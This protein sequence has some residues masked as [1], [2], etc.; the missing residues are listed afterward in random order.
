MTNCA[1]SYER[2][3][4]SGRGK[5]VCRR[6]LKNCLED[7]VAVVLLASLAVLLGLLVLLMLY[8]AANV[9]PIL[10][11]VYL[12]VLIP[13]ILYTVRT[14]VSVRNTDKEHY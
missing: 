11:P 14:I 3:R 13:T 2:C 5:D 8:V 7:K 10:Y 1:K 9:L 4:N 12:I 6:L